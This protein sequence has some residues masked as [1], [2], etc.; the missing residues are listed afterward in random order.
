M[1]LDTVIGPRKVIEIKD[2]K[3]IK[4]QELENCIIKDG[5]LSLFKTLTRR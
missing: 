4:V 1:P 5:E 2:N 3:T